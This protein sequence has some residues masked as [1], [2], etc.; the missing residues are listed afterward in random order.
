MLYESEKDM[1]PLDKEITYLEN[2]IEL[3]RLRL[4]S[5]SKV[6]FQVMGETT[7]KTIEPML[8][9][10]FIENAFKH[11]VDTEGADIIVS[12]EV[13]NS[14]LKLNVRNRVS[15]SQSKDESSGIGLVNIKKQLENRYPGKHR[16]KIEEKANTYIVDLN[17]ELK[18]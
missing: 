11:G 15:K 17:I 7:G 3:Q 1:V 16:L 6:S 13:S 8:M 4:T 14:D 9:I 2:Y 12:I 10:P 5:N 18:K